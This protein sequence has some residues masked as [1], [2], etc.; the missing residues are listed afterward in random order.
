M[1]IDATCSLLQARTF[2]YPVILQVHRFMIAVSRIAFNHDGKGGSAPD[3]LAWD[4]GGPRKVR[5]TDI[6][7]NVDLASLPGPCVFLNGTWMRFFP[8]LDV[9]VWPKSVGILCKFTAFLGS[10]HWPVDAVDM[11]HFG[12]SLLEFSSFSSNGLATG[13]SVKRSLGLIFGLTVLSLIPSAPVS[14]GAEIRQGCQFLSSLVRALAKLPGGLRRFL[15]CS[16]GSYM[17]RLR[18][19]GWNQCSHGLTSRPLESCHH[20]CLKAAC[21]VLA[22][23]EGS[24]AELLDG[25]LK[26]RC[27]TT[28]FTKSFPLWVLPRFGGRSGVGKI[29]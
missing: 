7:I 3:P 19:L 25:T 8:G 24:A 12:V 6:R 17:S 1:L 14:E 16:I 15:P 11:R 4:Q 23:P 10:L 20:Q 13:C 9:A 28:V 18:H 27:S 21:G 26:L 29:W 5:K 2:W 22:Y